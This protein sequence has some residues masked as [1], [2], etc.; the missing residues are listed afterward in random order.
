[1]RGLTATKAATVQL[2]VPVLASLGGVAFLAEV[3]T[4]R[5]AVASALILGGV[6][7]S[8]LHKRS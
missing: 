7:L 2:A 8:L 1:M 4:L 3:I 6:G 5:L